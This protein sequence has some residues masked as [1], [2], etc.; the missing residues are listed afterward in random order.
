[1]RDDFL[2]RDLRMRHEMASRLIQLDVL[3]NFQKR[4]AVN[5][6]SRE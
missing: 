3:S 1:M 6:Y 2:F 4:P 5:T